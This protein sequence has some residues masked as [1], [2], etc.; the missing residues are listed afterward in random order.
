MTPDLIISSILVFTKPTLLNSTKTEEFVSITLPKANS[1]SKS[2]SFS[3][4]F[5]FQS[6]LGI[7]N[8]MANISP[9]VK[10]NNTW[11]VKDD[12]LL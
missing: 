3:L 6:S 2:S 7:N 8:G 1:L 11:H 4:I 9:G 10:K 5:Y 12:K